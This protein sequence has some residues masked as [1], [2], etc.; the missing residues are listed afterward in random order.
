MKNLS[1]TA[2]LVAMYRALETECANPLFQDPYARTLAG[3]IGEALAEVIGEKKQATKVI[4]IRTYLIDELIGQIIKTEGIDTVVNLAAGLDTRP[5]R[6]SLPSSLRWIEVD[7]P[8]II[9]YKKQILT[10]AKP[11]C[12]L[13]RHQ[14]D[15][16]DIE[17]RN[18][19]FSEINNT[20]KKI[21]V[22]SEGLLSYLSPEQVESLASNLHAKSNFRWWLLELLSSPILEDSQK[23]YNRKI[24]DQYFG[25][26][27]S[28]LIFSPEEGAK[29]FQKY[30]WEVAESKSA[31]EESYRL[32]RSVKLSWLLKPLLR[33]FAK[34]TWE[35]I[36][37]QANI[38]LLRKV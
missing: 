19:L 10:T 26:G 9:D 5:Y 12:F 2:Y 4:A 6:L 18:N 8:E 15:L 32:N 34:N 23:T 36:S 3:G 27:D 33:R 14:L 7:L 31:W 29:F 13:E 11:K 1:E 20:G 22:I 16:N 17:S 24:F 35:N 30:G 25:N 28:T 38:V 37:Q 21:L